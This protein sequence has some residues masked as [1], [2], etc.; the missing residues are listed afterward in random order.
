MWAFDRTAI[1]LAHIFGLF[2]HKFDYFLF[3]IRF[4]DPTT[5]DR[6][7]KRP[8]I[9]RAGLCSRRGS[10]GPSA[11]LFWGLFECEKGYLC[12]LFLKDRNKIRSLKFKENSI[13]FNIRHFVTSKPFKFRP[14]VPSPGFLLQYAILTKI[15][16]TFC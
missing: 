5:K 9:A 11:P 1:T 15:C 6:I 8:K 16:K 13:F 7:F 12:S 2:G 4:F 14:S 3:L 10:S